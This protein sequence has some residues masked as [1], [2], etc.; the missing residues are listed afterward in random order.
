M[1]SHLSQ[2]KKSVNASTASAKPSL[3]STSLRFTCVVQPAKDD[4]PKQS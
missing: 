3:L 1:P 2:G 4:K